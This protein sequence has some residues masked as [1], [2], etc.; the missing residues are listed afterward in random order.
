MANIPLYIFTPEGMP[1]TGVEFELCSASRMSLAVP[2]PP[3]NR[4]RTTLRFIISFTAFFV[5]SAV[6]LVVI[7]IGKISAAKPAERVSS[8]P[9]EAGQVISWILWFNPNSFNFFRNFIPLLGAIGFAPMSTAF[10]ETLS[11]PFSPTFPPMPAMGFTRKPSFN[12]VF[13]QH[14]SCVIG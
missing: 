2:S 12:S 14:S 4:M 9:I 8:S 11:V 5:S 6:V 10:F 13:L 7:F 1:R 3:T